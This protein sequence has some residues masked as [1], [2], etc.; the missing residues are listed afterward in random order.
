M[1]R[2]GSIFRLLVVCTLLMAA[3]S[4]AHA[5]SSRTWVSGVGDDINPCTRTAPC[6]TFSSAM[7]KTAINGEINALDPGGFGTININK[8]L[9]I[10]G[11]GTLAGILSSFATAVNIN[12][13]DLSGNDPL[14]MVRL[15][16]LTLNGTG[17]S[18]SA[19]TR[20]GIRGINVSSSNP[21]IVLVVLEDLV[22]DNFTN[23]GIHFNSNGG[24]MAIR[25]VSARNNALAGLK[26]DSAGT[27]LNRVTVENSTF[28][29]NGNGI[30]VED[31]GRVS[32]TN[33]VLGHNVTGLNVTNATLSNQVNIHHSLIAENTAA[34]I[35]AAGPVTFSTVY[36]SDC[37]IAGNSN[38]ITVSGNGRIFSSLNNTFAGNAA[39][40][41]FTLPDNPVK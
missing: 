34:G 3:A 11:T 33:V 25:N 28:T 7:S 14:R 10:D 23:E 36:V 37:M 38:G 18:G 31:S 8:S 17:V 29:M 6:K 24:R 4:L 22:I 30:Q 9:T 2:A 26:V 16:G 19:G 35:N 1:N 40:G 39:D 21:T 5:Q 32:I 27:N 41:T 12:L 15:R 13:T 20:T